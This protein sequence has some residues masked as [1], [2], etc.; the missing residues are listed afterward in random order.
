MEVPLIIQDFNWRLNKKL[1]KSAVVTAIYALQ[2]LYR[3]SQRQVA[4]ITD[5]ELEPENRETRG[6]HLATAPQQPKGLRSKSCVLFKVE[7][8][9]YALYVCH[10][11]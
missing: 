5:S 2:L 6:N 11:L 7:H 8:P 10:I 4:L 1:R 3:Q 9:V